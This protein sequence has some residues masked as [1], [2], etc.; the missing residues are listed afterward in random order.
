MTLEPNGRGEQGGTGGMPDVTV[1][2]DGECAMCRRLAGF[3][4][5]GEAPGAARFIPFQAEEAEQALARAGK[6]APDPDTIYVLA[7]GEEGGRPPLERSSAVLYLLRRRGGPWRLAGALL[8]LLPRRVLDWGYDLV[9]RHR[10][11]LGRG[12]AGRAA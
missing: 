4:G 2:Y 9:A 10:R 1:V 3:A 8:G 6:P 11:G 5:R 7:R 12:G